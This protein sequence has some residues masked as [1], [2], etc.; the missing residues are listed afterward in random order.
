MREAEGMFGFWLGSTQHTFIDVMKKKFLCSQVAEREYC[1][2]L[3]LCESCV[4]S[5]LLLT[6]IFFLPD[7]GKESE[8]L[9]GEH[10]LKFI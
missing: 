2:T 3:T 1:S 4:K 6:N 5:W 9:T 7:F 8:G 10:T